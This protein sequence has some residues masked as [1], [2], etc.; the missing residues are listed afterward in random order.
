[1]RAAPRGLWLG[2][3]LTLG[4][5]KGSFAQK[6][7]TWQE[8]RDR[9]EMANPSLQAG[10]VGV[11]ESRAVEITAYLR[12]NPQFTLLTDGTQIAPYNGVWKPLAGTMLSTTVS[13]LHERNHK[14]EL[15]Q[16]SAQGATRI[17]VSQQADL[18]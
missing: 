11:E 1:M 9:F 5:A 3:I 15:R 14:R 16:E 13:Y 10:E 6:A 17:A 7:L 18:E 2:M 12:P 4:L 8:V